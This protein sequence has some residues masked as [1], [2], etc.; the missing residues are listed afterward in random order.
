MGHGRRSKN[1]VRHLM[2]K[3]ARNAANVN[4]ATSRNKMTTKQESLSKQRK[5]P[6]SA[7]N[8]QLELRSKKRAASITADYDFSRSKW[9]VKREFLSQLELNQIRHAMDVDNSK[10]NRRNKHKAIK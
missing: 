10:K 7:V 3:A 8:M 9:T 5:T 4:S 1:A 2:K 6:P